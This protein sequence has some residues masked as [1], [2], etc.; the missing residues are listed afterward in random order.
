[1]PLIMFL[2][3]IYCTQSD[4]QLKM[5]TVTL[6]KLTNILHIE[7]RSGKKAR[8]LNCLLLGS[9]KR[10]TSQNLYGD[11]KSTAPSLGS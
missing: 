9:L 11:P 8:L 7:M 2:F 10:W 5:P 4:E 6:G 1:M 3:V